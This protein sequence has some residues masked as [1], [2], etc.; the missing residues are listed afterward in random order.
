MSILRSAARNLSIVAGAPLITWLASFAFTIFLARDLG[1][2]P[3]GQLSLALAY[4]A[5]FTIFVDFGL[6]QHLSRIVAQRSGDPGQAVG[7]VML[8]RA[9]LWLLTMALAFAAATVLGYGPVLQQTIL[10]LA[11]SVLFG[12]IASALGAYLQGRE[13]FLPQ[14]FGALA[15]GL[16]T[17]GIGVLLVLRGLGI[18]GVAVAAVVGSVLEVAVLVVG[19]RGRGLVRP[20]IDARVA[21]LVLPGALPLALYL[22]VANFYFN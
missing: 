8:L 5:F 13:E 7:A 16:A 17:T 12:S 6:S 1:A 22:I 10:V 15:Q 3:F 11:V 20:R 19:A 14:S 18:L 2:E 9:G 21:L 4:V